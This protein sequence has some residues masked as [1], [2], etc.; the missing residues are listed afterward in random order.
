[1]HGLILETSI[2]VRQNQPGVLFYVLFSSPSILVSQFRNCFFLS[3]I[4]TKSFHLAM[5]SA[6]E[7]ISNRLHLNFFLC[8]NYFFHGFCLCPAVKSVLNR[9][10][11]DM[12]NAISR[13][14]KE[15]CEISKRFKE[16]NQYSN[17]NLKRT[18][19]NNAPI[20]KKIKFLLHFYILLLTTLH[21]H[22]S[23][24]SAAIYIGK[25]RNPSE[26]RS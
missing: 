16:C 22:S 24:T 18:V 13:H 9:I 19:W 10:G 20:N 3:S 17:E 25:H 23:F 15:R 5:P 14:W 2:Y 1:M 12:K 7:L 6:Q 4:T 21:T 26:L 11:K 8:L